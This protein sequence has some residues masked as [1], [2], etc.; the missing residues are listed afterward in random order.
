MAD[1]PYRYLPAL[2]DISGAMTS[3]S[4]SSGLV[5]VSP[6]HVTDTSL[7]PLLQEIDQIRQFMGRHP[8]DE[9]CLIFGFRATSDRE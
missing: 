8:R 6:T 7:L 4:R 9:G 1:D 5:G 3:T 2:L